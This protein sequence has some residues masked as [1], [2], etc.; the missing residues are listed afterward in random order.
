MNFKILVNDVYVLMMASVNLMRS[1]F[2][3]YF[4]TYF[5]PTYNYYMEDLNRRFK[6]FSD[7]ILL[8]ISST[9]H[10]VIGYMYVIFGINSAILGTFFSYIIR[11]ELSNSYSV[12][13]LDNF[14]VYNFAITMHGIIM[15][16]MFVMPVLIGGFGNVLLPI[17]V[18][19]PDMAF[20]RLNSMSF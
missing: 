4:H 7:L 6:T 5:E 10:K 2:L 13:V 17:M 14:H 11:T 16:F 8:A 12:L 9:D 18:G 19:S 20:P 1:Q 3:F 15:I